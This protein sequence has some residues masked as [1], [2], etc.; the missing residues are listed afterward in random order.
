MVA[1]LNP[2]KS[3]DYLILRLSR[4]TALIEQILLEGAIFKICPLW[5][6]PAPM[7]QCGATSETF[8]VGR[9][10]GAKM[11]V[12]LR[13]IS[14]DLSDNNNP[15]RSQRYLPFRP[16][17]SVY[18]ACIPLALQPLGCRKTGHSVGSA[19]AMGNLGGNRSLSF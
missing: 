14:R 16:V 1:S 18:R 3:Q 4:V 6:V 17:C 9:Q 13:P 15:L 2:R 11:T 7:T 5:P 19:I 10:I 8:S 12:G